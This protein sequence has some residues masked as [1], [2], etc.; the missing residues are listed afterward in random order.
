M[1]NE[2]GE[3]TELDHCISQG[4]P[5]KQN[6]YDTCVYACVFMYM[7]MHVYT[8]MYAHT[9]KKTDFEELAH[10]IVGSGKSRIYRVGQQAR[11][12]GRR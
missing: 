10:A 4:C 3:G 2:V 8:Y 12:S 5:E 6:Q 11:N 7:C 1:G 9:H